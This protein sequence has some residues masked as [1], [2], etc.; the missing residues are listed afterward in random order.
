[1]SSPRTFYAGADDVPA[2]DLPDAPARPAPRL[3]IVAD[4]TARGSVPFL[5]DADADVAA[6][7]AEESSPGAKADRLRELVRGLGGR[8]AYGGVAAPCADRAPTGF[9]ALDR[10]LGGGLVRGALNEVLSGAAGDGSA[11]ALLPALA[12]MSGRRLFAWIHPTRA[13]YPPALA[14]A[15]FDLRRWLVVRPADDEDHVFAL[16]LALRSGAC[17]AVV[18]HVGDLSDR[19]L[20]RLQTGA[21]EGRALAL[22]FRPA[23]LAPRASPAA[24]RLFAEPGVA[25]DPR[26]RRLVFRVLKARGL[27][28]SAEAVRLEWSRD[29]T[30]APPTSVLLRA[31]A[32]RAASRA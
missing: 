14:Q 22:L 26:R 16:D 9:E 27:A 24:V 12:R 6:P 32:G 21:E 17:D 8:V 31:A 10:A 7:G 28:A 11:E 13:P 4:A 5:R 3:R 15:G 23:A 25:P 19:L 18:A 1:M 20:R 29:P 30:D 2:D